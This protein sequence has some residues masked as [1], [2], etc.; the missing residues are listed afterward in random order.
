MPQNIFL[1]ISGGLK[2]IVI[3]GLFVYAIF[4]VIIVRQE[5]LMA[6]VLEEKYEPILRVITFIHLVAAV[7]II[8][9]AFKIL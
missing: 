1:I 8:L 5:Q 4:A 2:A 3:L 7:A 6:N 9:L